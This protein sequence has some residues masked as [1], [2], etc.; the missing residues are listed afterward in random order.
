MRMFCFSIK[1]YFKV[2]ERNEFYYNTFPSALI[3][4]INIIALILVTCSSRSLPE[5][6]KNE[7]IMIEPLRVTVAEERRN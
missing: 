1:I 7:V 3:I 4:K 6:P 2:N 5:A